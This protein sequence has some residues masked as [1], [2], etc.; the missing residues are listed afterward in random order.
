VLRDAAQDQTGNRR[1][2]KAEDQ[3]LRFALGSEGCHG[4]PEEEAYAA[5]GSI[6]RQEVESL[7]TEGKP[8]RPA[9]TRAM[10]EAVPA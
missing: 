4:S 9:T 7:P 1:E 8:L 3:Y 6:V 2:M 5:L 10:R